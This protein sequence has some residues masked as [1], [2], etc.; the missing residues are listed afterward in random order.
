MAFGT[1]R[2]RYRMLPAAAVAVAVCSD[3]ERPI[4]TVK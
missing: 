1:H 2:I 4:L 3:R